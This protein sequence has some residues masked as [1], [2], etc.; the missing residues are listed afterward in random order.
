M[1]IRNPAAPTLASRPH[2]H[3]VPANGAGLHTALLCVVYLAMA[4]L[5]TAAQWTLTGSGVFLT[6]TASALLCGVAATWS[7]TGP[8]T[9]AG[10]GLL[11]SFSLAVLLVGST[12]PEAHVEGMVIQGRTLMQARAYFLLDQWGDWFQAILAGRPVSLNTVFLLNMAWL[13]WWIAYFGVWTSLRYGQAWSATLT[14]CVVASVNTYYSPE[15]LTAI[16]VVFLFAALLL[17]TNAHLTRLQEQWARERVR[18]SQDMVFDLM[19]NGL[20]FSILVVGVA[21]AV[22]GLGVLP[23]LSLLLEP[24][25]Q[26]WETVTNQ[27]GDWNQGVRRQLRPGDSGFDASLSLGGPRNANPQPVMRVETL[28]GRY[29]RANIYDSYVDGTWL[30]TGTDRTRLPALRTFPAP[31][32]RLRHSRIQ[33]VTPLRDLGH[34]VLGAADIRQLSL[35]VVANYEV[36]PGTDFPLPEGGLTEAGPEEAPDRWELQHVRSTARLEPGMEYQLVSALPD[37]TQWDLAQADARVPSRLDDRYLQLPENLDARIVEMAR[38]VTTGTDNRYA[39]AKAI[40]A[41]LRGYAYD[42]SI[43]S[44][45]PDADPVGWFLFDI[46]RGYCDYYA[47]AMVLMLRSL[48]IHARLAAGYAEGIWEPETESFLV[49]GEDA[50]TW[51]EVYFPGLGWIEFEPTAGESELVRAPGGAPEPAVLQSRPASEPTRDGPPED[52]PGQLPEGGLLDDEAFDPGPAGPVLTT[53]YDQARLLLPVAA[54]AAALVLLVVLALRRRRAD[55]ASDPLVD[56]RLNG[57]YRSLLRWARS[58]E[59]PVLPTATPMERTG[60]LARHVPAAAAG[61]RQIGQAYTRLRF[62]PLRPGQFSTPDETAAERSWREIR[63]PLRAAWLRHQ[64]NRAASS[65]T[66]RATRPGRA[67]DGN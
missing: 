1:S 66:G 22:P 36:W 23:R 39:R 37:V 34:V 14:A 29:W 8:W 4:L 47:T 18:F 11:A 46:Q 2:R 52:P 38:L 54:G 7:R 19:R 67:A 59:L 16:Y 51:V 45:P 42:E 57:I 60:I 26:V 32:W 20:V 15:S 12:I 6:C 25:S 30:S 31:D 49:T 27:V 35:P 13:L 21:W 17:L 63:A 41:A 64:A 62:A 24:A 43:P 10:F 58:L 56:H 48:G 55:D 40:E 28:D 65:L 9:M 33:T 50:H 44:P 61:I 53:P 3:F 5:F